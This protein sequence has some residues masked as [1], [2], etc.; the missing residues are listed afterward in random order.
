M[1]SLKARLK[2]ER[3]R[4]AHG[5]WFVREESLQKILTKDA[6][7]RRISECDIPLEVRAEVV[8]H[9][10]TDAR[11]LF[12][13]LVRVEQEHL[14]AECLSYEIRDDKLPVIVPESMEGLDVDPKFFE[15]RWEFLAPIFR[16]RN[17]LLKLKD[18]Y[19]L[20]FLEDRRLDD[21]EGGFA[22]AFRV[23]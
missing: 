9:V 7:L 5:F 6:V 4:T 2:S 12:A 18:Q 16:R 19:I 3:R 17:V 22:N 20:P 11:I 1:T 23:T 8:D 21:S 13:I 10:L 15:K 14:I